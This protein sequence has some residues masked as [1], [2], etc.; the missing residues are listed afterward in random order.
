MQFDLPPVIAE[1]VAA[2]KQVRRHYREV[3]I[4]RGSDVDLR[5]TLDGNLIGDIGEALAAQLFDVRLVDAKSTE[6]IDGYTPDGRTVQVKA[7]GTG[8]GPAF[9]CVDTRADH[10]IFFDLDLEGGTGM[11]VFNGPEHY[12]TSHLP[13]VFPNQ[14]SLSANQIRRADALVKPQE[15]LPIIGENRTT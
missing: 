15:R 6:G 5:F 10:F 1:L 9:R 12:A 14:R 7:T 13:E 2:Q 3:L 11:I 4:E 8:R